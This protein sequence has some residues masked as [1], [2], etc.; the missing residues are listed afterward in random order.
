M[1]WS[2][3][4]EEKKK[5][6]VPNQIRLVISLSLLLLEVRYKSLNLVFSLFFSPLI[7][8]SFTTGVSQAEEA[9][10]SKKKNNQK[11]LF[12]F[13]FDLGVQMRVRSN[14]CAHSFTWL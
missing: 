10:R 2:C 9:A 4:L 5:F 6:P 1:E 11:N 3:K 14:A 7:S 8:L 13:D 12:F